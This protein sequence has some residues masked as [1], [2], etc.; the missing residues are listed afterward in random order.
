MKVHD[1]DILGSDNIRC[2]I[3]HEDFLVDPTTCKLYSNSVFDREKKDVYSFKS[4]VTDGSGRKS[5]GYVTVNVLDENDNRPLFPV[6]VF[7]ISVHT[8]Y[9]VGKYAAYITANDLDVGTNAAAL[10]SATVDDTF[11]LNDTNGG[12]KLNKDLKD[13]KNKKFIFTVSVRDRHAQLKNAAKALVY[14]NVLPP[15]T[16]PPVFEKKIYHFVVNENNAQNHVLGKVQAQ[17]VNSNSKTFI[18]YSIK[19]KHVDNMFDIDEFG[20][21]IAK[22]RID[23]EKNTMFELVVE[24]ADTLKPNLVT[25]T[26]VQ[27]TVVDVNDNT[28][29]FIAKDNLIKVI[30]GVPIGYFLYKC[31]VIDADSGVNGRIKFTIK[32]TTGHFTVHPD[33]GEVRTNGSLDFETI[34]NHVI[35]IQVA[36]GG[37]PSLSSLLRLDVRIKDLNDNVP[38]FFNTSYE[39][40][41]SE[42]QKVGNIVLTVGASDADSRQ[43]GDIFFTLVQNEDSH[44]FKMLSNGTIILIKSLDR[45]KKASYELRAVVQDRGQ[46]PLQSSA[47]IRVVVDDVN[48]EAPMFEKSF[49]QFEVLEELPPGTIVG[50]VTA[51]DRDEG[52]NGKFG[53]YIRDQHNFDFSTE[54]RNGLLVCIIKTKKRFDCESDV[55][56]YNIT[57]GASDYGKIGQTSKV[58]DKIVK[59]R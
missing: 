17:R 34:E 20:N 51:I 35:F 13:A 49:Y 6:S 2:E 15:S 37:E 38:Q 1:D 57:L 21:L 55:N 19:G 9:L 31:K 44:S 4:T 48:D 30:E 23:Y 46:P 12:L 7:N 22:Q 29:R 24:A 45:E 42:D 33:S 41:V 50:E 52:E 53:Y 32:N 18:T 27:I 54:K 5:H 56:I 3:V 16:R 11:T 47:E 39:V 25:N 43:N 26:T 28:P 10:Y 58:S 59:P 36:D 14:L 8:N 40:R